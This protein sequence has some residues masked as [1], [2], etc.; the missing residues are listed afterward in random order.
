MARIQPR[1]RLL[2]ATVLLACPLG[3]CGE[4]EHG[5]GAKTFAP[6]TC[7]VA[8]ID[9]AKARIPR[10]LNGIYFAQEVWLSYHSKEHEGQGYRF[11]RTRAEALHKIRQLCRQAHTGADIGALARQWS[12]AAGARAHGF[13]A[14][15]LPQNRAKPDARDVALFQ[16]PVGAITPLLEWRG[17]FWFAKRIAD[18][19]GRALGA[20]LEKAS[21]LRARARMIHIHHAGA[22]P[23]L[24]EFDNHPQAKAIA[25]ARWII[26]EAQKGA[27]FAALAK[28]WSNDVSRA[29][30]G[31]LET[32][33]PITGAKTEWIRWGDRKFSQQAL[34]VILAEGTP[35]EV[36][37]EPVISGQGVDVILVLERRDD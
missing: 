30:G 9:V 31:L 12:N 6:G 26:Q 32:K 18:K 1:L 21:K 29:Q 2:L 8:S 5:D 19:E 17:G 7:E 10:P 36:W 24:V 20:E 27:D 23:R 4:G 33:H 34:D 28:K 14:A 13:C 35:G 37:P 11:P 22:Y 16:T 3:A 15:P 25:T